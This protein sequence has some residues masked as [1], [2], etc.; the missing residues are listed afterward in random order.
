MKGIGIDIVEVIRFA[1]F[2]KNPQNRFLSNTF[3]PRELAYCFS[4]KDPVPHLAGTF[5]AKEAVFKALGKSDM[6]LSALEIKRGKNGKPIVLVKGHAQKK[7][8]VSISHTKAVAVATAFQ[9]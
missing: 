7:V 5:A 3:S 2:K 9:T 8:F 6:T 4:F 1:A